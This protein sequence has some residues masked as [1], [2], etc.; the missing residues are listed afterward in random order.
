MVARLFYL[1]KGRKRLFYSM[2]S[3]FPVN[4][5]SRKSFRKIKCVIFV[6]VISL[7][8]PCIID[9][10]D[11]LFTH[12][13][14]C[15]NSLARLFICI[16]I[17]YR[18]VLSNIELCICATFVSFETMYNTKY[19]TMQSTYGCIQNTSY[20]IKQMMDCHSEKVPTF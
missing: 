7:K 12:T 1:L 3:N 11:S 6:H 10:L 5:T 8:S 19:N 16:D 9:D 15:C 17:L 18:F 14:F 4:G 13:S 2:L 20:G